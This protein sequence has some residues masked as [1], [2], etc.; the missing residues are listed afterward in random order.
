MAA[1]SAGM[2]RELTSVTRFDRFCGPVPPP[3][4]A[5][6]AASAVQAGLALPSALR[7]P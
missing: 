7:S 1:N 6:A 3:Y 4:E 5:K 2:R